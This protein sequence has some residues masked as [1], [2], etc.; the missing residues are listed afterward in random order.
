[1]SSRGCRSLRRMRNFYNGTLS[2][3][4]AWTFPKSMVAEN[5]YGAL[6]NISQ[7]K[8]IPIDEY[9]SL[10]G[11]EPSRGNAVEVWYRSPFRRED[12][13]SFKLNRE[14]NAWYDFGLGQGGD[15]IDLVKLM[16]A[17]SSVAHALAT[18]EKRFDSPIQATLPS[19]LKPIKLVPEV[20]Q[21]GPISSRPL[22]QYL[23]S[24]AIPLEIASRYLQEIHYRRGNA[25]F[26]AIGLPNRK[27]KCLQ[28]AVER[29]GV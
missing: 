28:C 3:I 15:L 25:T 11:I 2:R 6:M 20:V 10:Q 21:A 5:G 23:L 26:F 17:T 8:R 29:K 13:P 9:L 14:L 19:E 27:A 24:R 12:T 1:M 7:A 18:I 16:E 22:E 4:L